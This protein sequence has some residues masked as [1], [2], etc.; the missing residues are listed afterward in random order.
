MPTL[1]QD[2]QK[3]DSYPLNWRA[4]QVFPALRTLSPAS[5]SLAMA[6]DRH[7]RG[8]MQE[9]SWRGLVSLMGLMLRLGLGI[10]GNCSPTC[11]GGLGV[12]K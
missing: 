10:S 5:L 12:R 4:T 8:M 7:P 1:Q 9:S 2:K 3:R 11:V 6:G